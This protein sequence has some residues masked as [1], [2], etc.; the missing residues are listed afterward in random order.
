MPGYLFAR[1]KGP[2]IIFILSDDHRWDAMSSTGHPFIKTP[3][4]DSL[5]ADG[6]LFENAFV[7]T[8]PLWAPFCP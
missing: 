2:N 3:H 8:I 5:A 1:Q 6:V 7:T 4:L